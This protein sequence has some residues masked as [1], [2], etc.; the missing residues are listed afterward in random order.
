VPLIPSQAVDISVKRRSSRAHGKIDSVSS[1]STCEGC[2]AFYTLIKGMIC[3]ILGCRLS[4]LPAGC[5]GQQIFLLNYIES[6][7]G[8]SSCYLL[9]SVWQHLLCKH[10]D[11]DS[12]DEKQQ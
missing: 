10:A 11:S 5:A 1:S 9:L 7:R 6:A 2:V 12:K 8:S 3:V 4:K